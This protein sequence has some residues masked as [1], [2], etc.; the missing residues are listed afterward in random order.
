MELDRDFIVTSQRKRVL[1]NEALPK[2][3]TLAFPHHFDGVVM[4]RPLLKTDESD[5]VRFYPTSFLF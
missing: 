1:F 2:A 3:S 4:S 5:S